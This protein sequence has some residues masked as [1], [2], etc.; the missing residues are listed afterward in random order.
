MGDGNKKLTFLI[1]KFCSSLNITEETEDNVNL[2]IQ[3]ILIQHKEYLRIPKTDFKENITKGLVECLKLQ[4]KDGNPNQIEV[5]SKSSVTTTPTPMKKR[6]R[7][8]S[9]SMEPPM[10]SADDNLTM[11]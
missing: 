4:K 6:K 9:S 1:K 7:P 3:N 10:E 11:V 2:L 8:Q 5:S